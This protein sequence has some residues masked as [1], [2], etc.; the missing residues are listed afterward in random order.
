MRL[1]PRWSAAL[2][3]GA[4]LMLVTGVLGGTVVVGGAGASY[5]IDG[6]DCTDINQVGEPGEVEVTEF[7]GDGSPSKTLQIAAAQ[8][9]VKELTGHTAGHGVAVAVL[10][11]GVEPQ[12]G[13]TVV[14]GK[15][16]D[17]AATTPDP[18]WYQGTLLAGVI[19]AGPDP[20][21]GQPVGIAPGA[22]IYD[23]R[24]YDT[25]TDT[26]DELTQVGPDS[27]AAGL[28]AI[29]PYVHKRG[30]RIV[31]VGVSVADTPRLRAAVDLVTRKGAIIVAA[32]G[33]RSDPDPEAP[34]AT[35]RDG[36]DYADFAWPAGYAKAGGEREAN[37]LVVSVT[38][39][40]AP[41]DGTADLALEDYILFSSAIDVAAP[42][43]G[44][45][46]LGLNE[47]FCAIREPSPAVAAAEVSGVLALLMTAYPHDSPKQLI[48][49]LEA[50]ASGAANVDPS[51]PNT[52]V[53]KGIVQP[54]E[55]LTRPLAPTR[56]GALPQSLLPEQE[57]APAVLPVPDPDVLASTRDNAVW[58]GLLGGGALIVLVLL[59][60]VLS[61]R[62]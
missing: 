56:K 4:V 26:N 51:T 14:R 44:V 34:A 1:S 33:A 49:R 20:K 25:G 58:W 28:E 30:I 6:D 13:L 23:E 32:S 15:P 36:E 18:V 57:A 62:R 12:T 42:T 47:R 37:P 27:V 55:A 52:R 8:R 2:S 41:G 53:G 45:V 39:T 40:A 17:G 59:R 19:A 38:T 5:A 3:R 54:L 22:A 43:G 29:A 48:T 61:R 21:S 35:Y 10:D 46:S 16:V 7:A 24:I 11:S 50:T 9:R 31:T 60:P